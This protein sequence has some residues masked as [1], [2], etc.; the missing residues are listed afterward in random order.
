MKKRPDRSKFQISDSELKK[1][2]DSKILDTPERVLRYCRA[3]RFT[4]NDGIETNIEALIRSHKDDIDL[5]FIDLGNNDG[6][7]KKIRGNRYEIAINANHSR[8]RRKFTMAHEYAHYQIHRNN[9]DVFSEGEAILFRNSERNMYEH[10]AN[11][12]AADILMPE[13]RFNQLFNSKKGD[14]L[15]IANAFGVSES[16][17]KFRAKTLG[18]G[19]HGL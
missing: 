2:A 6:Y 19:G 18:Y 9:K 5:E 1:L 7:I 11:R 13:D 16:A 15:E 17:I 12:F 8:E 4:I 14:I 10:Q 3:K